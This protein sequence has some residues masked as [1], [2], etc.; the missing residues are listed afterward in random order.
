M[1]QQVKYVV[2]DIESIPNAPLIKQVKYPH[3]SIGEHD[4]VIKFQEE[5]LN[6][7]D[8]STWFIPVTFQ[9]PVIVSMLEVDEKFFPIRM[10]T[11]DEPQFRTEVI[12]NQFWEAIESIYNDASYVTFN[13]RGFD[14]PLMELMAFRFG[15]TAKRHFKDKFASR[16]RFGTKHIDIHDW[17]SNYSAIRM[18]GGLNLLA[19]VIDKPGKVEM[20]GD[21][22]YDLF[23]EG[24]L[25]SIHEYCI[26]DVMDTYFVFLRTRVMIGELSREREGVIIQHT[27]DFLE[28]NKS[29]VKG[30][31][32]YLTNWK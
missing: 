29:A 21:D 25:Q 24:K 19:K 31:E 13:G 32:Q 9:L 17:L 30:F 4:A 1:E 14:F 15:V 3:L 23:K 12:V 10:H 7:S 18:Q 22:V 11:L 28:K 2:F 20:T 16:F 5:I 6:V 26:S 8:G 27:R